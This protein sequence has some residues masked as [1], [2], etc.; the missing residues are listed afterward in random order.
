MGKIIKKEKEYA[1]TECIQVVD[2][3]PENYIN[4]DFF[5][6]KVYTKKQ[7]IATFQLEFETDDWY[8]YGPDWGT[9]PHSLVD[10]IRRNNCTLKG[11]GMYGQTIVFPSDFEEAEGQLQFL[12]PYNSGI[13]INIIGVRLENN[14]VPALN[15]IV[16][17]ES[18][19]TISKYIPSYSPDIISRQNIIKF[20]KIKLEHYIGNNDARMI[21]QLMLA[22][23]KIEPVDVAQEDNMSPITSNAVYEA[24]Q[25]GSADTFI[26]TH[27]EWNQKTT[28]E[29][30]AYTIVN[31]TDDYYGMD[32]GWQLAWSGNV[33]LPN[34][35]GRTGIIL[36]SDLHISNAKE[37]VLVLDTTNGDRTIN[38]IIV[39]HIP[40]I[41]GT[42]SSVY[43]GNNGYSACAS[44]AV[45][46]DNGTVKGNFVCSGWDFTNAL[47]SIYFR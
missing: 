19:S 37:V 34:T 8:H 46:F 7:I 5:Y 25:T 22:K 45:D 24:L 15:F 28:E 6:T 13:W 10:A 38:T 41:V 40:G 26:G 43:T 35:D 33:T 32:A 39:P 3:L 21:D 14:N 17:D 23:D 29:K 9:N 2:S 27:D 44:F 42:G 30:K 31:F 4:D 12:Y 16:T 18:G 11:S 47:R 1:N 36:V 20:R